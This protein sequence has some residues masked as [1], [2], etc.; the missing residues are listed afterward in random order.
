MKKL[1]Y[2]TTNIQG[3]GGVSRILSVKLNYLITVFNYQVAIIE[4]NKNGN[5]FFY[6]FDKSISFHYI[7]T[8]NIFK[9]NKELKSCINAINPDII[10]NCDNGLK[11]ALLTYLIPKNKII[12]YE[13]HCSKYVAVPNLYARIKLK[14]TTILLQYHIERY[15]AFIVLNSHEKNN[16]YGSNIIVMP[17]PSWF[18]D[19][20]TNNPKNTKVAIAV[21]RHDHVKAYNKLIKIWE[22]VVKSNPDWMLKIYGEKNK[23]L[24]LEL[25]V[26]NLSLENNVKFMDPVN[27]VEKIYA[28][29]KMLLST[30]ISES[31]PMVFLEAMAY[32]IP[33]ISFEGTSGLSD[34]VKNGENGFLV[35]NHNTLGYVEKIN[36]LI[37]NEN[38]RNKMGE[39]AKASITKFNIHAVM[40]QWDNLFN[41]GT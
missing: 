5:G 11:G 34:L 1:L 38:L 9:Y 33:V 39:H 13:R 23:D 36:T 25:L 2:I 40:K 8:K 37:L 21:G 15:T 4:T 29:A 12:I 6:D 35:T 16:W 20:K 14:L 18:L 26:K 30:S 3:S 27:D 17:N 22:R 31:F 41:T 10:A 32:G 19:E 7:N 28:E 24:A